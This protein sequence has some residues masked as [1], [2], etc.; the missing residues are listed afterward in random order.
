VG[1]GTSNAVG[2]VPSR[3]AGWLLA[4]LYSALFLVYGAHLPYWPAWLEARG[5]SGTGLGVLL[6]S[7]YLLRVVLLPLVTAWASRHGDVRGTIRLLL[8]TAGVGFLVATRLGPSAGAA[9]VVSLATGLLLLPLTPL[10]DSVAVDQARAGG[11][12]YGRVRVVGSLAFIVANL[13]VGVL[14]ARLGIEVL[15]V[16][17]A[18]CA[19]GGCAIALALPAAPLPPAPAVVP[20]AASW[21]SKIPQVWREPGVMRLLVAAGLVQ[22]SHGVYYSFGTLHWQQLGY[23][24]DRIGQLW[25]LAVAAEVLLFAK[26]GALERRFSPQGLVAIGGGLAVLRWVATAF[27][28]ALPLLALLQVLHAASFAATHVGAV[29]FLARA[30]GP[31]LGATAL[32]IYAALASG[33]FM[34]LVTLAAGPLYQ[35]WGGASYTLAALAAV[36]GL[37]LLPRRGQAVAGSP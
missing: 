37:A 26:A 11:V 19:V 34:G 30:V 5:L 22:G 14:V 20:A 36:V 8:A 25:G 21:L 18:A 15:P 27:D 1:H 12:V 32:G 6:A 28:P 16:W 33:L 10:V 9:V 29:A 31:G 23:S 4:S 7:S 35:R 3:S 13:A 24:S 2:T 17:L